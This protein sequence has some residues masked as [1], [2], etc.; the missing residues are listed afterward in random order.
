[1]EQIQI[2]YLIGVLILF[3]LVYVVILDDPSRRNKKKMLARNKH[4][5]FTFTK[6][7]EQEFNKS[8]SEIGLNVSLSNYQKIRLIFLCTLILFGKIDIVLAIIL[9]FISEPKEYI[10]G[11]KTV[12]KILIDFSKEKYKEEQ[13]K[14]I[15]SALVQLKN[16]AI[17]TK[18]KPL[19]TDFILR[20]LT[21]FTKK[22]RVVFN[23]TLVLWRE[24][25]EET[26]CNY[27]S[28]TIGTKLASEFANFVVKL[29]KVNPDELIEQLQVLQEGYRER[30]ITKEQKRQEVIS[31]IAF[32]PIVISSLVVMMNFI[33]ITIW[34]KMFV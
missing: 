24:S 15:Y 25:N 7:D 12:F 22:T 10:L 26:A 9:F 32:M 33:I 23:H 20:Q 8:M 21:K 18:E 13:D 16:L 28:E 4:K 19:A 6:V 29:D 2:I 27:F 1:M 31:S 5:Y 30:N 17:A 14:E 3:Y 34:N 11:R